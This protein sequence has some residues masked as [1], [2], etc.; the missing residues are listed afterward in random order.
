MAAQDLTGKKANFMS[1]CVAQTKALTDAYRALRS[2][3]QEWTSEGYSTGITQN[4]ITGANL[5]LTPAILANL[6]STF[7]IIDQPINSN[8]PNL[9]GNVG[10]L[11]NLDNVKG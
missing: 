8:A 5:H 11:T 9:N 7:D 10:Y 6:M 3:R 4:D 1:N 2:L